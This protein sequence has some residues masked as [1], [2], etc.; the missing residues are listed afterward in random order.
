MWRLMCLTLS[1]AREERRRIYV[2]PLS[3]IGAVWIMIGVRGLDAEA[4]NSSMLE[5]G[6]LDSDLI[7]K[8]LKYSQWCVVDGY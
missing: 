8:S 4:C 5:L 1:D 6:E 3:V 2:C 7:C